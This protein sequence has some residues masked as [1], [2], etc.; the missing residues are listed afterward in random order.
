MTSEYI[1][2]LRHTFATNQFYLGMPDLYIS[3]WMGHSKVNITKDVY[4][5]VEYRLN[6]EKIKQLYGELF[7]QI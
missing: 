7:C 2:T 4:M 5:S 1:K 6:A 3:K